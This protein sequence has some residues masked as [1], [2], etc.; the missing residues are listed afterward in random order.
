M[1][2]VSINALTEWNVWRRRIK[3]HSSVRWEDV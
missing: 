1:T 3:S 2:R